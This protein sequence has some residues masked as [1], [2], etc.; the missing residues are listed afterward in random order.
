MAILLRRGKVEGEF[1]EWEKMKSLRKEGA[2]R[3]SGFSS[4]T[5]I[6]PTEEPGKHRSIRMAGR[7]RAV[8]L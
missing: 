8:P 4:R 2:G 6:L 7:S 1:L 3:S 5:R